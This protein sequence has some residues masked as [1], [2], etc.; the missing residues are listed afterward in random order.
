MFDFLLLLKK[1]A[2][3]TDK[4]ILTQANSIPPPQ[5]IFSTAPNPELCSA[6]KVLDWV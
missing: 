2:L 1:I 6:V 5:E 4:I 3:F